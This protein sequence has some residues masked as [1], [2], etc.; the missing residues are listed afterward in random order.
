MIM[1]KISYP[2]HPVRCIITGS[3]E[4]GKSAFL[5]NSIF[6]IINEYEK[7]I[8]IYPRSLHQ[9]L[10]QNYLNVLATVYQLI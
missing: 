2:N 1:E 5:T 9:E 7:I 10:Y 8:Y 6:N 4:C 3:S